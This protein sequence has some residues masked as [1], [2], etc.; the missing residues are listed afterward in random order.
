MKNKQCMFVCTQSGVRA[1][2]IALLVMLPALVFSACG[3]VDNGKDTQSEKTLPAQQTSKIAI[4]NASSCAIPTSSSATISAVKT[5]E[6]AKQVEKQ[7]AA[8]Q[9]NDGVIE[10]GGSTYADDQ[11]VLDQLDKELDGLLNDLDSTKKDD[12]SMTSSQ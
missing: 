7:P 9:S 2:F 8:Q 4:N 5:R 12:A 1:I 3:K 10:G 11:K 6:N